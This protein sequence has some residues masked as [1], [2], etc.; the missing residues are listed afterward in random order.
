MIKPTMRSN[1][2]RPDV[3]APGTLS[4]RRVGSGLDQVLVIGGSPENGNGWRWFRLGRDIGST[5]NIHT[6]VLDGSHT[7]RPPN[8]FRSVLELRSPLPRPDA[9][10][11]MIGR[12]A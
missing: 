12:D 7:P 9:R 3:D 11:E 10:N 4:W 5:L 1:D 6:Q 2:D 8:K